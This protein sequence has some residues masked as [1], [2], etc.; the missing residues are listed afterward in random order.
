MIL[1]RR[2]IVLL[3][4]K[5]WVDLLFLKKLFMEDRETNF[6]GKIFWR[7]VVLHGGTNDEIMP[8]GKEAGVVTNAF[9]SNLNIFPN[10]GEI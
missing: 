2:G 7:G 1:W 5:V 8:R 4:E 6:P 10:H 9:S 3:P